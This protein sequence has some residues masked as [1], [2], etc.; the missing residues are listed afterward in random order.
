MNMKHLRKI[1]EGDEWG[2]DIELVK[3]I[4]IDIKDEYPSINGEFQH[5]LNSNGGTLKLFC[6]P[7]DISYYRGSINHDKSIIGKYEYGVIEYYHKKNKFILLITEICDRIS[8][9][10]DREIRVVGLYDFDSPS[11]DGVIKIHIIHK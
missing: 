6:K 10:L 5:D 7:G 1:F 8:D 9:A 4:I 11:S 3:D 2:F